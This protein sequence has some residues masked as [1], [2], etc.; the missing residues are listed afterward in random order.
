MLVV[1]ELRFPILLYSLRSYSDSQ[2]ITETI[3]TESSYLYSASSGLG[4]T[5]G[6]ASTDSYLVS[7]AHFLIPVSDPLHSVERV[8]ICSE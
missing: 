3:I 1:I 5:L 7:V 4:T 2:T 8:S 6:V